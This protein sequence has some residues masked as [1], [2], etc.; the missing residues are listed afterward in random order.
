MILIEKV[1]FGCKDTR[2]V[3]HFESTRI[4][5]KR[6]LDIG[7]DIIFRKIIKANVEV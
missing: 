2:W 1:C 4:I 3:Y 7:L 5:N 6:T